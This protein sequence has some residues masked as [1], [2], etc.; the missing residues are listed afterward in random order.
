MHLY[1]INA[2]NDL[3]KNII[4]MNSGVHVATKDEQTIATL[5]ALEEKGVS[6]TVCGTCLDFYSLLDELQVGEIGNMYDIT[7]ILTSS[8]KVVTI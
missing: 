6:I 2:N 4:C 3:P 7:K 8:S 5:Q 1:T